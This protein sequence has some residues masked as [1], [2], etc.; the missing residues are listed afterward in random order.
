MIKARCARRRF[1]IVLRRRTLPDLS[2]EPIGY[3]DRSMDQ[4][5]NFPNPV[6]RTD[7]PMRRRRWPK[8]LAAAGVM[9]LLVLVFLPQILSSKVGRKV[10]VSYLSTKLNGP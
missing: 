5:M 4:E 2:E 1:S 6:V 7:L 9:G 8:V 3:T 10:V